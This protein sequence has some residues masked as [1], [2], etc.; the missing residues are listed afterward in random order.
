[1]VAEH[2]RS[3]LLRARRLVNHSSFATLV[4]TSNHHIT[5]ASLVVALCEASFV[6][7][8][9][10]GQI[11]TVAVSGMQA[12]GTPDGVTFDVAAASVAAPFAHAPAINN[13][14][15]VSF[16]SNLDG[17][18]V[19]AANN[20]GL[21]A[22]APGNVHLLVRSGDVINTP[23][24]VDTWTL[25]TSDFKYWYPK[26]INS[27]GRVSFDGMVSDIAHPATGIADDASAALVARVGDPAPGTPG[28]VYSPAFVITNLLPKLPVPATN[29]SGQV[30][31]VAGTLPAPR[32]S[33]IWAGAPTALAPVGQTGEH[34]PGTPDG[35]TFGGSEIFGDATTFGVPSLNSSGQVAFT[36][37]L[38]G[39]GV[40]EGQNDFGIWM[41]GPRGLTLVARWGDQAEGAPAGVVYSMPDSLHPEDFARAEINAAGQVAFRGKMVGIGGGEAI[42]AGAPGQLGIVARAGAPAPGVLGS[43]N[44]KELWQ[45]LLNRA[46]NV[47]FIAALDD[48]SSLTGIWAGAP[49]NLTLVARQGD[50][51]PG[52][53]AGVDFGD[54]SITLGG[55]PGD[56]QPN[57]PVINA[58][59]QVAFLD[60]ELSD[61]SA[62]IWATDLLGN[63]VKIVRTGEPLEVAPG[64]F[65]MVSGLQFAGFSGNEDGRASGFNDLGQVAF[66]AEFTDGTAGIFISNAVAAVPEPGTLALAVLGAAILF[67][68][69]GWQV[70][71]AAP[72]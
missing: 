55:V 63:L 57:A 49:G 54:L 17:D 33:G 16:L 48:P 58:Q 23:T 15:Q 26:P 31:F 38:E 50:H 46:G 70:G 29:D 69:R 64:D 8:A 11:I 71:Q 5:F 9:A 51:A 18:G 65:R 52:T 61:S 34:A 2:R 72:A 13:G 1:M 67:V 41:N 47:A 66:R 19:S 45:P 44:F 40:T 3:L 20:A 56:L 6:S 10:A 35:V 42:W 62:G 28:R 25:S 7:F 60:D 4:R 24:G 36:A 68:R 53:P 37:F 39:Q 12:P 22:G 14:G 21:W 30:A 32:T 43:V 27:A 59:G